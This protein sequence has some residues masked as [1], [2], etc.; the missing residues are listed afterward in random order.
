MDYLNK[1]MNPWRGNFGSSEFR[2]GFYTPF[3][4]RSIIGAV[5][6]AMGADPEPVMIGYLEY[7]GQPGIPG[8][9]RDV[10]K[11][12]WGT[13]KILEPFYWGPELVPAVI[14]HEN[15]QLAVDSLIVCCEHTWGWYPGA[16][17]SIARFNDSDRI[18]TNRKLVDGWGLLHY[19]F[20]LRR[21]RVHESH[22]GYGLYT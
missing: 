13:D 22:Y 11:H 7:G 6:D 20:A 3:P 2:H 16:M 8:L 18:W 17:G 1:R 5:G 19:Q 21:P 12:Y 4:I 15:Q 10:L 9:S 14:T